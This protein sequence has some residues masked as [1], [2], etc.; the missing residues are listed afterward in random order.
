MKSRFALSVAL[1]VLSCM[2]VT[3]QEPDQK[4]VLLGFNAGVNYGI[5]S[6]TDEVPE[7]V[8]VNN[9]EGLRLGLVMEYKIN[10]Y[11][12]I[13]PQTE[14]SFSNANIANDL[15]DAN[16]EAYSLF[17]SAMEFMTHIRVSATDNK[18]HPVFY[19]G[20]NFKLPLQSK[21]AK[22]TDFNHSADLAIDFGFALENKFK[23]FV[24]SPELRFSKGLLNVS[25]HPLY[26]NVNYNSLSLILTFKG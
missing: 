20:P 23:D 26:R 13:A 24:F 22:S 17:A 2:S 18:I 7:N 1:L 25:E 11:L 19:V 8:S 14:L 9:G 6:Y 4:K 16:S 5:V 21:A 12:S 10:N 3:A 15:N